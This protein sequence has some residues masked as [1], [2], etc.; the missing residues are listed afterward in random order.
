MQY[1]GEQRRQKLAH[2][3]PQKKMKAQTK[4]TT[5]TAIAVPTGL[6][7]YSL[8]DWAQIVDNGA[9]RMLMQVGRGAAH[10][11]AHTFIDFHWK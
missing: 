8:A 7:A 10:I 5:A 3:K 1:T 11:K 4:A 9:E 6:L 2:A